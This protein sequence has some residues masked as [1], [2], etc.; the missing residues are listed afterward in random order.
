MSDFLSATPLPVLLLAGL[1]AIA[2]LRYS[3]SLGRLAVNLFARGGVSLKKYG[4]GTGAWAVITGA[5]DGIG[6]EFALQLAKAKFNVVIL[7]RTES[8]LVELAQEIRDTH[9]VEVKVIPF[10]FSTTATADYT[11]LG[12]QLAALDIGVLVNNVGT[13]H[14]F[15]IPFLEEQATVVD[16]IVNVNI[17]SILKVT[18]LVAPAMVTKK[19]GLILNVGSFAGLLPQPLLSVYSGSKSFLLTWS[20]ALGREL[21]PAKVDVQCLSTYFVVSNMS[22]IR[23]PSAMIPTARTYVRQALAKLGNP[24]GANTPFTSTPNPMHALVNWII[25]HVG[26]NNMWLEYVYGTQTDIRKRALKKQQRLAGNTE[27]KKTQ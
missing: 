12:T 22:K 10:D 19:R 17:S 24:G 21:K 18:Q 7:A 11:R 14:E 27:G 26:T 3:F 4:A 13:N 2:L 5:S 1:G 6:K 16:R 15:P 8:K 9:K 20:Q 23:K 25:N